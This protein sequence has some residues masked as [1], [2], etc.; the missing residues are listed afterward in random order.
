MADNDYTNSEK[1]RIAILSPYPSDYISFSGGV[2]TA[3]AALLEGLTSYQE[4]FDF[5]VICLSET[6]TSNRREKH[7]G[8]F[9]HFIG[10]PDHPW[11]RPRVIG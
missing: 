4:E 5:H 3:E 7:N 6:V 10:I 2:E 9:F 1:P 11:L 8:F